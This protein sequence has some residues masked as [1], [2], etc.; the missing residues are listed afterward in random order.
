MIVSKILEAIV[1]V[2]IGYLTQTI[3]SS[4][5]TLSFDMISTDIMYIIGLMLLTFLLDSMNVFLRNWVGQKG[6]LN[7]RVKV[8]SHMMHLPLSFFDHN[9]VGRLMTRTI[10]D[11]EQIDQMF[12]ES[13]VPILSNLILFFCI[14]GS[15]IWLNWQLAL[16]VFLVV[17]ILWF[18][19][20]RFR[21]EQRRCYEL[22]RSILSSMNGF[23]QEHLMG[24]NIIRNFGLQR[25]EKKK[26]QEINKDY[27]YANIE[28]IY[29][30]SFFLSSIE[31]LQS[32]VLISVFVFLGYL[33]LPTHS[34]QAGTFFTVTLYASM[35]FRPILDLAER[36]NVLQNALAASRRIFDILDTQPETSIQSS[37]HPFN[38]I[39]E[40]CFENVW[41][42]YEPNN[43]VLK[44]V[45]FT[46]KKGES[47]ALV[48]VTGSGKTSIIS[49][50]LR[51]YDIQKG[52]IR[53]NGVDIRDIP[54]E[55]LRSYY[56]L[57]L[58]DPS[59][60]SGTVLENIALYK[61]HI[62]EQ[63]VDKILK[64]LDLQDFIKKFSDGYQHNL[65]EHGTSLSTGENQLI[66]LAR[67]IAQNRPIIILD[68]A[69]ANIDSYTEHLIQNTLEKILP[70]K[71]SIIIAHRLSTIHNVTK[72]IVLANGSIMES[73]SHAELIERDSLYSKLYK[74]QL[75]NI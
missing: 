32:V 53:M 6:I 30:F 40:I 15:L 5:H 59:I 12:S 71:T 24:V 47:I 58:Q 45:S 1:P 13:L 19:S 34:F 35:I 29:N 42:S 44:N 25:Q 36:F 64:A 74:L 66:A 22:L 43:W 10:H 11:V 2:L 31:F 65:E 18:L 3:L 70:N 46:V 75:L 38:D 21:I 27:Q 33:A 67:A 63:A 54:L 51:F 41:F 16:V 4:R 7:L 57:V 37:E 14:A 9:P 72:I 61:P 62:T 49:L 60:F 48:G 55:T 17:P 52:T 73:G 68:E 26:F 50:L 28:S 20:H 23:I 8:F 56:S 69:T 39:Q